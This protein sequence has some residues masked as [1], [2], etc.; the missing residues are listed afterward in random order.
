M[1]N[2]NLI[3]KF[4]YRNLKEKDNNTDEESFGSPMSEDDNSFNDMSKNNKEKIKYIAYTIVHKKDFKEFFLVRYEYNRFH[5]FPYIFASEYSTDIDFRDEHECGTNFKILEKH[6]PDKNIIE[7]QEDETAK[8][9][10]DIECK[11]EEEGIMCDTNENK[12]YTENNKGEKEIWFIAKYISETPDEVVES[13]YHYEKDIASSTWVR[14]INIFEFLYQEKADYI[15]SFK[16]V[17]KCIFDNDIHLST[18]AKENIKDAFLHEKVKKRITQNL[19]QISFYDEKE[20]IYPFINNANNVIFKS[21]EGKIGFLILNKERN[22]LFAANLE[23]EGWTTTFYP[24]CS[25]KKDISIRIL[26]NDNYKFPP[27]NITVFKGKLDMTNKGN[28]DIFHFEDDTPKFMISTR[29]IESVLDDI[30][31]KS[32]IFCKKDKGGKAY[33]TINKNGE[34]NLIILIVA[35]YGEPIHNSRKLIGNSEEYINDTDLR[36]DECFTTITY[37]FTEIE[38]AK[39]FGF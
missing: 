32:G 8:L 10:E 18:N 1:D 17:L 4:M 38:I 7:C 6:F 25:F 19:Q 21:I 26:D 14:N 37:L 39:L 36:S 30:S 5:T 35:E 2:N 33:M 22:K 15:Q 3:N 27:Q 11:I 28:R 31:N 16:K 23:K 13:Y 9:F 24:N 12:H 20:K 29:K 34:I